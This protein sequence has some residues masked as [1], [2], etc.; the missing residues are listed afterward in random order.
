MSPAGTNASWGGMYW[1][2]A[3]SAAHDS[4]DEICS[5]AGLSCLET[6]DMGKSGADTCS[7]SAHATDRFLVLCY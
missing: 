5:L 7:F 4:G 2:D 3:N 6:Y 1:G